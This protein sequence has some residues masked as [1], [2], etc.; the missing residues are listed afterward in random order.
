MTTIPKSRKI[1][2]FDAP[3]ITPP[4]EIPDDIDTDFIADFFDYSSLLNG[5]L[6]DEVR[7]KVAEMGVALA[8]GSTVTQL[9]GD[10]V[11]EGLSLVHAWF[12]PHLSLFRHSHPSAGDCLYFVLKGSI[13][14]GSRSLGAG[15]GFFVPAAAAYKFKAG[16]DGV[17][18]LEFRGGGGVAGAPDIKLE[19]SSL[20]DLQRV[21]DTAN[22][23]RHDWRAP[24]TVG[25]SACTG[26]SCES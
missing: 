17:E 21:I 16:P 19:E 20:N 24:T 10:P 8:P 11:G 12:G 3:T 7:S 14:M 26:V 23:H 18:V 25:G 6:E 22:A 15:A 9:F 4:G 2:L 13:A 1:E 5:L